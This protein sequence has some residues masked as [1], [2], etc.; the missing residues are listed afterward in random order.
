[1]RTI[2]RGLETVTT[3]VETNKKN[4]NIKIEFKIKI[5]IYK[6]KNKN[7]FIPHY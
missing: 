1:M 2:M 3:F 6:N 5:K 4:K 7:F